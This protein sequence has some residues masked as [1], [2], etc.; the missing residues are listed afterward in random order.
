MLAASLLSDAEVTRSGRYS[1]GT[2]LRNS[3]DDAAD[4]EGSRPR[5][6][7]GIRRHGVC[8]RAGPGAA[9][10]RGDVIQLLLSVTVHEHPS[11][12]KTLTIN[13]CASESVDWKSGETQ[14]VQGGGPEAARTVV[15]PEAAVRG[16]VV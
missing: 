13:V 16:A 1:G 10:P 5:R 11:S 12:V 3:Q 2:L 15:A 6:T 8:H 4:G 14:Y 7:A 9:R